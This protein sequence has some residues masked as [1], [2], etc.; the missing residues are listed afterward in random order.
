M[1]LGYVFGDHLMVMTTPSLMLRAMMMSATFE[2]EVP[3]VEGKAKGGFRRAKGR[4]RP[5][6]KES[7]S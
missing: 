3:S 6:T 5:G 1:M 2:A 7:H 4:V